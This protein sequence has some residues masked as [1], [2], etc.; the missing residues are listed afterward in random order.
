[1]PSW[2]QIG[3]DG[4]ALWATDLY[5]PPPLHPWVKVDQAVRPLPPKNTQ[6]FGRLNIKA[7]ISVQSQLINL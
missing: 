4:G 2:K 1:M 5:L 7:D 6:H 3:P